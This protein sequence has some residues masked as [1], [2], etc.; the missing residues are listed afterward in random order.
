MTDSINDLKPGQQLTPE[1]RA[2]LA[3]DNANASAEAHRMASEQQ[4]RDIAEGRGEPPVQTVASLLKKKLQ[5]EEF[6]NN[7]KNSA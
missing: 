5:N 2:K 3:K 1:Q 6:E 4:A 7:I